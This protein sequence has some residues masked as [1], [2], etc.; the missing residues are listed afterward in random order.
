MLI[1]L[2]LSVFAVSS[3]TIVGLIV[4]CV[5]VILFVV[6]YLLQQRRKSVWKLFADQHGLSWK[7]SRSAEGDLVLEVA[8]MVSGFQVLLTTVPEGSDTGE[9]GV[10]DLQMKILMQLN[11]VPADLQIHSA[12]G[13]IGEL[14][15]SLEAHRVLGGDENFDRHVVVTSEDEFGTKRWLTNQRQQAIEQLVTTQHDKQVTLDKTGITLET[16]TA[17]SRLETLN[18]MLQSLLNAARAIT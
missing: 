3:T 12:T 6:T 4:I 13:F 16:R 8:G 11:E 5:M 1:A 10:E 18:E 15:K 2:P 17:I 7:E 14:Q 9:M